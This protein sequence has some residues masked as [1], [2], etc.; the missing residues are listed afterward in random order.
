MRYGRSF[1]ND[2]FDDK[3]DSDFEKDIR[4]VKLWAILAGIVSL[5]IALGI[6]AFL[7]WII[8]M[9]MRYFGVI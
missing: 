4:F 9:V 1:D 7:G 5:A 2:K 8:V 3:F 6:L